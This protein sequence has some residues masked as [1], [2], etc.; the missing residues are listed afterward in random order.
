MQQVSLFHHKK[1]LSFGG[2]HLN[3]NK[4]L[5]ILL[6]SA[7][8]HVFSILMMRKHARWIMD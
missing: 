8:K 1:K 7:S 2:H 4:V 6:L 3:G 5:A